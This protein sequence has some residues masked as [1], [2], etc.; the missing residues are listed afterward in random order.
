MYCQ[1]CGGAVDGAFCTKC[2]ARAGA[3]A[4]V[5]AP[6]KKSG[7]GMKILFIVLGI[8]V[9]IGLLFTAGLFWVGHKVT[10]TVK[11]SGIDLS[12]IA[13][14]SKLPPMRLDACSLLS[15]DE[16]TKLA[17]VKIERSDGSGPAEHSQCSYYSASGQQMQVVT[18]TR[19]AKAAMAG[20]RIATSVVESEKTKMRELVSGVGDE[21]IAMPSVGLLIFRKGRVSVQI[22]APQLEASRDTLVAIGREMASKI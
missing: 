9:A 19:G 11:K 6:P 2:G 8:I 17:Q 12:D 21:A 3:A 5:P 13:E 7:N 4:G 10:E 1:V 18:Q 15:A 20:V 14:D 16:L 22:T